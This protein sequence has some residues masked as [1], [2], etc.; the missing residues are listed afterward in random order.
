MLSKRRLGFLILIILTICIIAI[1]VIIM[2]VLINLEETHLNPKWDYY[3]EPGIYTAQEEI[4]EGNITYTLWTYIYRDFMPISPP[5]GKPLI[6]GIRV[7]A[8]NIENFPLTTK[9]ER[10]WII[11]GTKINSTLAT[12]ELSIDGSIYELVFREG[13]KWEPG[14]KIDVVV[15]LNTSVNIY[16]LKA[17]NQT[18]H[19]TW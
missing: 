1:P 15:K 16:Y 19:S 2:S 4:N 5:A 13:P 3:V 8:N 14:L 9:I 10:L 6:A 12:D 18:I 11:N 17:I 7:Y